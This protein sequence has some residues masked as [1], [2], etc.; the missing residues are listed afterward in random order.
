MKK[1]YYNSHYINS[2]DIDTVIDSLKKNK[3][4]QGSYQN[5][6][7]EKIKKKFNVKY[8]IA[9]SS[10]TAGLHLAYKALGLTKNDYIITS[11]MTWNAT[12]NAA[13]F[14][15]ASSKLVDIS[16]KTFC[17]DHKKLESFILKAKK[18]P[19]II[20]PVHFGSSL[21]N[22]KKISQIAKK[23]KIKVVEDASQAMGGSYGKH[24]IGSCKY[25]DVTIFSLHP[26]KTITSGEGGLVL[27]NSYKTYKQVKLMRSHS[28]FNSVKKEPWSTKASNIGFNYRITEMQCALAYSQLKKLDKFLIKRSVIRREYINQLK[29]YIG[30]IDFQ[31]INYSDKSSNHMMIIK[32]N[33]TNFNLKKKYKI[34]NFFIKNNIHLT[35]KYFPLHKQ[36]PFFLKKKKDFYNTEEYYLRTFCFPIYYSLKKNEI[37]H[38]TNLI[39][40]AINIFKLHV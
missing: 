7:E 1:Y 13:L 8:C 36:Y 2:N 5:K 23:F 35:T 19:K 24:I 18:K 17:I 11:S 21:C 22:L 29:D 25:S 10:A 16:D 4:S 38:I 39:K 34:Y 30:S 31:E 28:T 3:L 20:V 15:N 37:I 6:L 33:S 26:V 14:C 12:T 32:F 27:T 9:V 40:K